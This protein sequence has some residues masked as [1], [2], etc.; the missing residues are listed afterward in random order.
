[1]SQTPDVCVHHSGVD[2]KLDAMQNRLIENIDNQKRIHER[3]DKVNNGL[4]EIKNMLIDH[5]DS[6]D[7]KILEYTTA[8]NDQQIKIQTVLLEALHGKD[9]LESRL[10]KLEWNWGLTIWGGGITVTAITGFVMALKQPIG[11]FIKW[12]FF[13]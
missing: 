11:K 13:G 4:D 9:G 10:K 3:I 8:I 1:M 5:R 12:F 7:K 6:I 2:V